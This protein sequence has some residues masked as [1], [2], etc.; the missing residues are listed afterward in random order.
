MFSLIPLEA[1]TY[2][3]AQGAVVNLLVLY[4][5]AMAVGVY[6]GT[7]FVK[8]Q[9]VRAGVLIGLCTSVAFFIW[10]NL[11]LM[12]NPLILDSAWWVFE[13]VFAVA[14]A[15]TAIIIGAAGALLAWGTVLVGREIMDMI[16]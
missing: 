12:P 8:G 4:S 6:L 11:A 13:L 3:L 1:R 15:L 14:L 2:D 10:Y 16:R 9:P 7:F 5:M